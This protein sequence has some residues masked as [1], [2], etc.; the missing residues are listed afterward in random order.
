M[1]NHRYQ[2]VIGTIVGIIFL[3]AMAAAANPH[4]HQTHEQALRSKASTSNCFTAPAV[5]SI[6][7]WLTCEHQSLTDSMNLLVWCQDHSRHVGDN[8]WTHVPPRCKEIWLG[9]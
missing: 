4:P 2:K 8:H 7:D 9:E 5:H 6:G 3:I 1:T